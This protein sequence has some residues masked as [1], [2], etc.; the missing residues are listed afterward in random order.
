MWLGLCLQ[1]YKQEDTVRCREWEFWLP[2][3]CHRYLALP[4]SL[5]CTACLSSM[6]AISTAAQFVI[7]P[8]LG[9]DK[10]SEEL[11]CTACDPMIEVPVGRFQD[12]GPQRV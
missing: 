12:L 5:K 4:G 11:S 8:V 10:H 6:V 1:Y 2:M 7:S 3:H 9:W